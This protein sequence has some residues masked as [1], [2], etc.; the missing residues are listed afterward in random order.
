MHVDRFVDEFFEGVK[1]GDGLDGGG[2]RVPAVN[3]ARD[4]PFK[5]G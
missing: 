1:R 3:K 4:E 5:P 2:E